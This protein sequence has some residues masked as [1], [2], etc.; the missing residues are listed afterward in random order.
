[1]RAALVVWGV[2]IVGAAGVFVALESR[3]SQDA[4]RSAQSASLTL[5]PPG[6][7]SAARVAAE[8]ARA[9]EPVPAARRTPAVQARCQPKGAR[10]ASKPLGVH[11]ALPLRH[12][13]S[14]PC[15]GAARRLLQRR[16]DGRHRRMLHQGPNARL[17]VIPAGQHLEQATRRPIQGIVRFPAAT[18][19]RPAPAGLHECRRSASRAPAAVPPS[20]RRRCRR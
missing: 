2:L 5:A 6:V 10:V 12:A 17:T 9:P 15:A 19:R 14:L 1:M 3:G 8:V 11:G 20:T 4:F 13:G 18:R 7:L 16:G